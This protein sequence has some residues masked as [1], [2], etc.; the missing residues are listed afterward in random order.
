[1]QI[2]IFFKKKRDKF[3]CFILF[4]IVLR[5]INFIKQDAIEELNADFESQSGIF[6]KKE[7]IGKHEKVGRHSRQY[8]NRQAEIKRLR[9]GR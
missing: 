7:Y 8:F 4:P 5:I 3:I 2:Y 9:G 6:A 1:M